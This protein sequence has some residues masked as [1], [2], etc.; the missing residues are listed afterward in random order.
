MLIWIQ[1]RKLIRRLQKS[2]KKLVLIIRFRH[3]QGRRFQLDAGEKIW[4]VD[5]NNISDQIEFV[6][7]PAGVQV[8]PAK[9]GLT[10]T[11]N[12]SFA[13]KSITLNYR[14]MGLPTG[15]G[16]LYLCGRKQAE[17]STLE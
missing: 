5:K 10:V 16:R 2:G 3:I 12:A 7:L 8:A 15:G 9:G 13:G 14:K 17:G 1:K 6:N 4:I 11:T